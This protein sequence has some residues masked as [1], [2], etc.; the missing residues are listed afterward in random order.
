MRARH[1]PAWILTTL[2]YSEPGTP[3]TPGSG[4]GWCEWR[5][6][7]HGPLARVR[8]CRSWQAGRTRGP[9]GRAGSWGRSPPASP[10]VPQGLCAAAHLPGLSS[11]CARLI[12]TSIQ[13]L[14]DRPLLRDTHPGHPRAASLSQPCPCGT[15]PPPRRR[16][17][18]PAL[19]VPPKLRPESG[20]A[21]PEV[22]PGPWSSTGS[23]ARGSG[24]GVTGGGRGQG[25][26]ERGCGGLSGVSLS[27]AR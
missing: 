19:L 11:V 21:S 2:T 9:G 24:P 27:R 8:W 3:G 10:G 7:W 15:F 6:E 17:Q 4:G 13:S 22:E 20:W 5:G 26:W 14:L 23:A 16:H 12:H 25:A 1:P 18:A